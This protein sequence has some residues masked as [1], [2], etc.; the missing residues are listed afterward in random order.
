MRWT[1]LATLT[2]VA[3][4][5]LMSVASATVLRVPGEYPTIQAGIDVAVDGDTVLVGDGTY[6]GEGNRDI[7]F[8]GK[9]IVVMSENGPDVTIIDCQADSTDPHRGFY[10]HRFEDANSVVQGFMITHG[11]ASRGGG[12]Y[13]GEFC[14]PTIVGNTIME[15][16]AVGQHGRGGGISCHDSSTIA[17]NMIAANMAD[18]EGGGIYCSSASPT[19]TGNTVIGNMALDDG[20]GIHCSYCSPIIQRNIFTQNTAYD[21]GGGFSCWNSSSTIECNVITGNIAYQRGGGVFCLSG[22]STIAGNIL[23]GNAAEYGGAL[24]S[25]DSSLIIAGNTLTMNQAFT[26][27]GAICC[28]GT[29]NPPTIANCILWHDLPEE[30]PVFPGAPIV[31]YCDVEGGWPG[32]GNIDVDPRFV[33]S[34]RQDF[35]LLWQSPC[36]DAGHPNPS[37]NDPD[38]TRSD[39]GAYF[40]DQS[41]TLV[42]YATPE[43]RT[44]HRGETY[45]VLYTLVNCHG[46]PQP[47]RGVVELTLPNGEPWPG[48]PLEGPGYGVMPPEFNWHCTRQYMIPEAMPLGTWGFA[49]KVGM[50]GNLFDKDSFALTV[51]EP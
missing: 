10:F 50:P 21:K 49:W 13:C 46:D 30:I 26:S 37:Y 20:G 40:F 33:L 43:A 23:A 39:I 34:E 12:I 19:I 35:R 1:R 38:G 14:S 42:T 24:Y 45:Q 15:N 48:N 3:A 22:S 6:T 27:G 5:A 7:D 29:Q 36:I 51:V 18:N 2:C 17:H 8:C 41:K 44:L 9:A 11:C 16:R 31:I 25:L 4:V 28:Y 32:V 47:V